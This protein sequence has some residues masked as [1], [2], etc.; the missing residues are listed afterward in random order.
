[1]RYNDM[2]WSIQAQL[3]KVLDGKYEECS[4]NALLIISD[5][6]KCAAYHGCEAADIQYQELQRYLNP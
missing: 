3:G 4:R 6:F 2:G 1:M 5:F